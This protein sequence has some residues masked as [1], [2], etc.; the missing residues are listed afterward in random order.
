MRFSILIC[1]HNRTQVL[2]RAL[3]AIASLHV[4]SE[5]GCELVVVDNASTDDTRQVVERFAQTAPMPVRYLLEERLGKSNALN[6]G[7]AACRGDYVAF[8]DDDACPDPNWLVEVNNA[9]ETFH[10]DWVYGR[11]FPLWDGP[12]PTWFSPLFYGTFALLDQGSRCFVAT[13][14]NPAFFGVNC[15]CRRDVP[16]SLGG[17]LSGTGPTGDTPIGGEDT[18]IFERSLAKGL[19]I[20]YNPQAIVHHIISVSRATKKDQRRRAWRGGQEWF[21][22]LGKTYPE[23]TWLLGLPRFLYRRAFGDSLAYLKYTFIGD[24]KNAF[25]KEVQLIKFLG[26]FYQSWRNGFRYPTPGQ[27]AAPVLEHRSRSPISI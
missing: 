17:Y 3:A 7:I 16:L 15:A 23:V 6:T 22:Y 18:E 10:A 20:V 14:S 11:V 26:M 5:W 8:T 19:C 4:P 27:V 2:P 21:R 25:F 13:P 24:T 12:V 9:F 1:T